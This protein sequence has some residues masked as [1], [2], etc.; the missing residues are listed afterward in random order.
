MMEINILVILT[1][2][3]VIL[4]DQ[5]WFASEFKLDNIDKI[6]HQNDNP[7]NYCKSVDG[8]FWKKIRQSGSYCPRKLYRQD[9]YFNKI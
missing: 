7:I 1:F 4:I 2:K 3:Q 9:W 8:F 6:N 5:G